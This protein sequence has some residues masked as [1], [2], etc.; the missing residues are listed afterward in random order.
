[1]LASVA[2]SNKKPIIPFYKASRL[3]K[4]KVA[5]TWEYVHIMNVFTINEHKIIVNDPYFL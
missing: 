2:D 4:D 5:S 3:K 1:M